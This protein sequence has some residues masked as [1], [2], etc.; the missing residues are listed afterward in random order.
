MKNVVIISLGDG[1]FKPQEVK[2]G[3]YADGYYQVLSGLT[4]G[5]TIVTSAQFLIDSESNLKA[6]INQFQSSTKEEK[7]EMKNEQPKVEVEKP[8]IEM[9]AEHNHSSS[10]V[11]EGTFD[12]DSIDK[13]NKA[14]NISTFSFH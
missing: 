10:I 3:G 6:A 12:V 1:K 5:N 9:D 7:P 11:H 13:N 2:L 4:E 14:T 8:K